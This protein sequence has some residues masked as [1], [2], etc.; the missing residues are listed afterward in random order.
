[1]AIQCGEAMGARSLRLVFG[2]SI[3]RRLALVFVNIFWGV[4][5]I[6]LY[7]DSR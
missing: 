1:M 4:S 3:E 7:L 2:R 6:Y 5:Y